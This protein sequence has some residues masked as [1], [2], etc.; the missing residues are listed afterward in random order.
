MSSTSCLGSPRYVYFCPSHPKSPLRR[1]RLRSTGSDLHAL[2]NSQ[3]FAL[4]LAR[5]AISALMSMFSL[6]PQF[7]S[8]SLVFLWL[9]LLLASLPFLRAQSTAPFNSNA[10]GVD[11]HP[12]INRASR[13]YRWGVLVVRSQGS[14]N[15]MTGFAERNLATTLT[16]E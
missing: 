3:P 13:P 10:G 7:R 5:Q 2:G 8:R 16:R 15:K 14:R 12:H 9:W 4:G 11:V 6:H 1:W